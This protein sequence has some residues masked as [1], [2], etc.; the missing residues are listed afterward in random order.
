MKGYKEWLTH[1]ALRLV[2]PRLAVALLVGLV[3][4]LAD[5]QLLDGAVARA[6]LAALGQP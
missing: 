3:G 2:A 6:V 4:I 5:A 1:V